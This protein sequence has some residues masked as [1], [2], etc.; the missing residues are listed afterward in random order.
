MSNAVPISVGYGLRF[1]AGPGR[2]SPVIGDRSEKSC[3]SLWRAIPEGY[4]KARSYSDFW[5]A[6]QKEG[7]GGVHAFV[8]VQ[9]QVDVTG[10]AVNGDE[11]VELVLAEVDLGGVDAQETGFVGFEGLGGGLSLVRQQGR[12]SG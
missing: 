9:F 12:P 7:G 4:K 2:S 8:V 3:Q 5:G 6:Y 10:G 1:A 11:Q